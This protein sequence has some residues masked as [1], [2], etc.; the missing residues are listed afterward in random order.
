MGLAAFIDNHVIVREVSEIHTK[1]PDGTSG[2]HTTADGWLSW[3]RTLGIWARRKRDD[4]NEYGR[5]AVPRYGMG[6]HKE[7]LLLLPRKRMGDGFQWH[8]RDIAK[9]KTWGILLLSAVRNKSAH[10]EHVVS[11]ADILLF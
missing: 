3:G 8:H 11:W 1:K 4:L 2:P 6:F 7:T 5:S 10:H 9:S